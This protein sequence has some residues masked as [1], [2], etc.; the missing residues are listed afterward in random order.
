DVCSSDLNPMA[1]TA[2]MGRGRRSVTADLKEPSGIATALQLIERAD[3]VLEGFR[4]GVME[5]LGLAP[6]RC[7]ER[8]PR[9]VY[10]RMTGFGQHGPLAEAPGHDINY[11]ALTG[12]LHAIGEADGPP[13]PPLNLIGDL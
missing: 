3:V 1:F 11:I 2:V 9:L 6:E 4:P 5:R 7:F 12:A 13:V 8:N 10:A